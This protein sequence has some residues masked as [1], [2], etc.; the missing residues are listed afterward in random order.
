MRSPLPPPH[1]LLTPGCRGR[2]E[3]GSFSGG[4]TVSNGA[5]LVAA[6]P[7]SQEL[8]LHPLLQEVT[9]GLLGPYGRRVALAVASEIKVWGAGAAQVL[10]RD[11][12]EWPLDLLAQK[13]PGAEMELA[14]MWAVSDFEVEGGATTVVPVRAPK[15]LVWRS[16]R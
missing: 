11:D 8:A 10:H 2:A 14:C 12:E 9:E 5:Y 4:N 3:E 13:K 6:C 16:L 7:T 1:P 15:P